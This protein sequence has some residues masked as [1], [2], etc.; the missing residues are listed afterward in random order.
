MRRLL[1]VKSG[2]YRSVLRSH[3]QRSGAGDYS[4]RRR[5]VA[6]AIQG[7]NDRNRAV[8]GDVGGDRHQSARPVSPLQESLL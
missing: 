4:V 2:L 6:V 8:D 7:S 5:T 1:G 3:R